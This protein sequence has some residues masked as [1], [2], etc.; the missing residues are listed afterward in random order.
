MRIKIVAMAAVLVS[1]TLTGC[2]AQ[3][4]NPAVNDAPDWV[5]RGSG[6]YGGDS[7]QAFYGVG[8]ASR[9]RN[10]ALRRKQSDA[11]ARASIAQV[12]NTYVKSLEKSYQQSIS[13]GDDEYEASEEQV[14][15]STLKAYTEQQLIGVQIIDHWISPEGDEYALAR[16][17]FDMFKDGATRLKQLNERAKAAILQRAD[18][19]FRELEA[20]SDR[21]RDAR[22]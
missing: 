8:I 9:V 18:D 22:R 2:A 15:S 4:A 16:L 12:L 20:E 7:D 10:V 14:V 11:Q 19:A 13:N 5:T 3:K 17:D 21:T 1:L 6:A